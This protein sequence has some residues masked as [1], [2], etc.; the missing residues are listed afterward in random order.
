[1]ELGVT[2]RLLDD[3]DGHRCRDGARGGRSAAGAPAHCPCAVGPHSGK[4]RAA[5]SQRRAE[6]PV[7]RASQLA[8]RVA[9]RGVHR[10]IPLT[11]IGSDSLLTWSQPAQSIRRPRLL[12]SP[13]EDI[14]H[15]TFATPPRFTD[16]AQLRWLER[17]TTRGPRRP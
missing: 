16:A 1:M 7:R 8:S 3:G 11:T 2:E 10:P 13:D 6:R 12:P 17:Q 4:S 5:S 15:K 9:A 14:G